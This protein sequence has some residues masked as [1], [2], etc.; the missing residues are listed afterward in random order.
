MHDV[1]YVEC[2]FFKIFIFKR[3]HVAQRGQLVH[4]SFLLARLKQFLNFWMKFIERNNV[5]KSHSVRFSWLK[6]FDYDQ[7]DMQGGVS[8]VNIPGF[9]Q[10]Y[11]AGG[12]C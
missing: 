11:L 12:R 8:G 9:L 3:L 1:I 4:D 5:I 2:L 6:L 7:K 10:K